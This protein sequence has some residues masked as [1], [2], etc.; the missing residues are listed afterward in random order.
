MKEEFTNQQIFDLNIPDFETLEMTS[1]SEKYLKIIIFNRILFSIF[2]LSAF[3]M[4]YYFSHQYFTDSQIILIF[5]VIIL[6][7]AAMITTAWIGFKY[8]KY[9]LREKDIVY[10]YGWLKRSLII[11]P[12]NR[13]QHIKIEQGWFSKILHLKSI[14]VFTAGVNGGDVNV[15]GLPEDIAENINRLIMKTIKVQNPEDEGRI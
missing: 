9:A 13:I 14:T 11:V 5:S 8:R 4:G 10:Q 6:S 2:L 7:I 15:S 12:I 3:S 1:V